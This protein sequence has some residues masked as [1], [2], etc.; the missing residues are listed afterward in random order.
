MIVGMK[1]AMLR[2]PKGCHRDRL[3]LPFRVMLR[4]QG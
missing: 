3:R 4:Q 2:A 1:L